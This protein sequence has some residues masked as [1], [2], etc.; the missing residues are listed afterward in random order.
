MRVCVCIIY[1]VLASAAAP[2][3]GG[4]SV[5]LGQHCAIPIIVV[6]AVHFTYIRHTPYRNNIIIIVSGGRMR[7][8]CVVMDQ[9]YEAS[10]AGRQ[11]NT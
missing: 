2:R 10:G 6:C 11:N 7:V 4:G 5:L 9:P 8:W 1:F 3:S